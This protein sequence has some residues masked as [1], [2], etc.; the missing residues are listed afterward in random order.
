M[1]NKNFFK[2]T[3]YFP[4]GMSKAFNYSAYC[5]AMETVINFFMLWL[6]QINFFFRLQTKNPA[7]ISAGLVNRNF[8][9]F[10]LIQ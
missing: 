7:V 2:K 4:L 5:L 3:K 10:I 9:R 1:S 8:I 6:C